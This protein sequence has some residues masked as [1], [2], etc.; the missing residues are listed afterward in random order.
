MPSRVILRAAILLTRTA[1]SRLVIAATILK[2]YIGPAALIRA[3]QP[4]CLLDC[5]EAISDVVL[6]RK[7]PRLWSVC[8]VNRCGMR[9]ETSNPLSGFVDFLRLH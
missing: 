3:L 7:C 6:S 5:L 8:E 1:A 9:N 2:A 4:R